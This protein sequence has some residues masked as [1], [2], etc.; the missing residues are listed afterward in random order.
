ME[1]Q[2]KIRG[3]RDSGVGVR[4]RERTHHGPALA[5][6]HR[7]IVGTQVDRDDLEAH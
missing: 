1:P 2:A 4:G 5:G 7:V 6:V 3:D